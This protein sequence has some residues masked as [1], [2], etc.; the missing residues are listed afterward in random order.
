MLKE[1]TGLQ[2]ADIAMQLGFGSSRYFSRCFKA[3]YGMAPG[4]YRK[5]Q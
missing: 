2:I 5:K 4:E 3:C 1:N